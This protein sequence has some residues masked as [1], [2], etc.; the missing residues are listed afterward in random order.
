MCDLFGLTP[1]NTLNSVNFDIFN[2]DGVEDPLIN[3]NKLATL[4]FEESYFA[5]AV[6]FINECNDEY[7]SNKIK[8]YHNISEASTQTVV[9]E[10][11]SDFFV[12]VKEIISKFL[13]FIKS[14]FR[15]FLTTLAKIVGSDKYLEKHKKDFSNFK[16]GDKFEFEGFEYTFSENVPLAQ[17]ALSFSNSLFDKLYANQNNALTADGIRQSIIEMDLEEDYNVF[18]AKVIGKEEY[19]KI[20]V[21]DFPDELF[22]VY[23]NGDTMTSTIEVDRSYIIKA[24]DRYFSYSKTQTYVNRQYKNIEDAYKRVESQVKDVVSRN[25]DLNTKEFLSRLPSDNGI[26]TIGTQNVEDTSKLTGITMPGEVMAQLDIYV[27]AKVDQIQEYSNIHTLAFAAKLDALKECYIQD[28]NTLYTAL[29][30]IERTI[31]KR[32]ES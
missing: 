27:K 9:L 1:S 31:K 22:K 5:Q 17:A 2:I 14:L 18:R 13:K 10:S 26:K 29:T 23:R 12:K 21:T 30:R 6:K 24:V 8:L 15:R 19:N 11:F 4:D 32:E 28:K 16:E 7:T 25:G 3:V 20:S